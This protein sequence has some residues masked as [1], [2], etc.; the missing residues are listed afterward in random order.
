MLLHFSPTRRRS[1]CCAKTTPTSKALLYTYL[2]LDHPSSRSANSP[3]ISPRIIV[4]DFTAPGC[5]LP[6]VPQPGGAGQSHP[7]SAYRSFGPGSQ[8]RRTHTE[9]WLSGTGGKVMSQGWMF[10]KA[11]SAWYPCNSDLSMYYVL[12]KIYLTEDSV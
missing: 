3:R 9:N 8:S 6:A 11:S 10:E 5:L 1:I 2:H 7:R 12:C 4:I